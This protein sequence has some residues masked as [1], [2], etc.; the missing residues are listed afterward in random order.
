MSSQTKVIPLPTCGRYPWSKCRCTY[1][2]LVFIRMRRY[3]LYQ[4]LPLW[5]LS[6]NHWILWYLG[7]VSVLSSYHTNNAGK[8]HVLHTIDSYLS[9]FQST[10]L[11]IYMMWDC[12]WF[13]SQDNKGENQLYSSTVI[14]PNAYEI[15][16]DW[17]T[18]NDSSQSK[19]WDLFI[20]QHPN[21]WQCKSKQLKF[22]RSALFTQRILMH[23]CSFV[24]CMQTLYCH[25]GAQPFSLERHEAPT[26][27]FYTQLS[28]SLHAHNDFRFQSGLRS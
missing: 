14:I 25:H 13:K 6:S 20:D 15:L 10:N 18:N 9:H 11:C 12:F 17:F 1:S 21:T 19:Y 7:L 27:L 16:F 26:G 24:V 2:N 23:F 28:I 22:T 8:V 4:R 3:F 5:T